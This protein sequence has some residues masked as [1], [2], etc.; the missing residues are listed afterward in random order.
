[1][2]KDR[3]EFFFNKWIKI[4]G[5]SDWRIRLVYEN[6][7]DPGTY[8]EVYRSQNY[9]QAKLVV[10]PWWLGDDKVP[11]DIWFCPDITDEN[12]FEETLV[13]ELL[14]LFTT[15]MKN[16]VYFD[17][18]GFLHRDV[19]VQ[20]EKT[21]NRAEERSVDNLAVAL[22]RAFREKEESGRGENGPLS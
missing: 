21:F 1:M 6:S 7:D 22:C 16:I 4:L 13:H 8:M 14:H 17:L 18:D 2:T 9:Q 19:Q 12:F 10:P 5:L 11:E 3:I 20:I 15:P